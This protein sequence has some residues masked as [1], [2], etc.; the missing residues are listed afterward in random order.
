MA[1]PQYSG[2][3]FAME[4]L[5]LVIGNYKGFLIDPLY[6]TTSQKYFVLYQVTHE[7]SHMVRGL[8]NFFLKTREP[9]NLIST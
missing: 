7:F 1:L 6:A 5:G 2:S 8:L 9:K 3:D 4:N